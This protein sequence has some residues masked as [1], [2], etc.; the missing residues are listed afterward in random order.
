MKTI[1]GFFVVLLAG[2]LV[3]AS[4]CSKSFQNKLAAGMA[5]ASYFGSS[6]VTVGTA[7]RTSLDKGSRSL[8]TVT[9]KDVKW[10]DYEEIQLEM[11]GCL[12][13]HDF[14][15]KL[16]PGDVK[17]DEYIG[18]NLEDAMNGT[19]E[20]EY[21]VSDLLELDGPMK[22]AQQF[23]DAFRK[24]DEAG[25]AAVSDTSYLNHTAMVQIIGLNQWVDSAFGGSPRAMV[26]D[27]LKS[28]AEMEEGEKAYQIILVEKTKD[29]KIRY[30]LN[31]DRK[32]KKVIGVSYD[33]KAIK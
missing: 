26:Y 28:E 20:L 9:V 12:A 11:L 16:L 27:G 13:A 23:Y 14:L 17:N 7:A 3:L 1:K 18:I 5:V 25:V 29:L 22:T 15:K 2:G 10:Q 19:K 4:G 33:S 32:S 24:R 6:N 8:T 30:L 21:K 31:I